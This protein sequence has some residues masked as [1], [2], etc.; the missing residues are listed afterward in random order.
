VFL[1]STT[2][3]PGTKLVKNE[4]YPAIEADYKRVEVEKALPCEEYSSPR[5]RRHS[6]DRRSPQQRPQAKETR[7]SSTHRGAGPRSTDPRRHFWRSWRS[8]AAGGQ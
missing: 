7:C 5:M 8:S 1:G 2:V 3:N 4:K 6:A